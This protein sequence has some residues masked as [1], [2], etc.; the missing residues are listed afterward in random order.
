VAGTPRASSHESC[1]RR[2]AA[3]PVI[4]ARVR[5]LVLALAAALALG[6]PAAAQPPAG[7]LVVGDS[8]QVGSGPYLEAALGAVSAE[9]DH[10]TGRGSAEGLSVL[11]S[12][13]RADHAAVV[14]D[15]GTNDDPALPDAL[16]SNLAAARDAVGTRCLVVATI[17]RPAVGGVTDVGL[18]AALRRFADES[19]T[20]QLVDWREVATRTPGLLYPDG[21][22]ARSEGY[23]LRGR[24]LAR[25]VKSCLGLGAEGLPP[26]ASPPPPPDDLP[27]LE[28]EPEPEVPAVVL[29]RLELPAGLTAVAE[30][31]RRAADLLAAA[32]RDVRQAA[33]AEIPEPVLG[34]PE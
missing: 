29:P 12:R 10:R 22:H 18:N 2:V 23:E 11:R 26:P 1:D 8:L 6:S 25:A 15:L 5:P 3:G 13:L 16:A 9:I 24:L 4:I 31:L 17:L 27:G 19:P 30:T 28:P 21:I 33:G 34:A 20:V 7:V 14:F 32:G